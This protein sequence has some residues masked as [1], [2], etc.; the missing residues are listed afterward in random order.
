MSNIELDVRPR[1]KNDEGEG[2]EEEEAKGAMPSTT[3][4]SIVL[5]VL[6][7][8]LF[9]VAADCGCGPKCVNYSD[10]TKCTRCC[11]HAVKRA[12]RHAADARRQFAWSDIDYHHRPWKTPEPSTNLLLSKII[13]YLRTK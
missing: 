2:E 5:L 13:D 1:R 9:P 11:T 7:Y 3:Q 4:F 12:L 10:A 6:I 8:Q